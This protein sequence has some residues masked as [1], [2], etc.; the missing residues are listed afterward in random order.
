MLRYRLWPLLFKRVEVSEV[1]LDAPRIRVVQLSK[2]TFNF[3]DMT[4]KKAGEA[5]PPTKPATE[6]GKKAPLNLQISQ[7]ALTDGE[8][9]YEDRSV[10]PARPFSYKVTGIQVSA[11]D[12][13]LENPFPFTVKAKLPGATLA[14]DGTAAN[15]SNKPALDATFKVIDADLRLLTDALPPEVKEKLAALA[16]SGVI[17]VRLHLAGEVAAP[18][19]L[20]KDG[21]VRLSNVQASAGGQRPA[22]TCLLYTSPSPRD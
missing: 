17:N 8:V 11:K 21:E 15:V 14:F 18:K 7:V 19:N 9:T 6:E 16:P 12:I 13:S 22:L 10:T 3:S 1:R 20:L 5:P 4:A 2:G